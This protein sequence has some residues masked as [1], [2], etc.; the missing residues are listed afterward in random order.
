VVK[1]NILEGLLIILLTVGSGCGIASFVF[2]LD[3]YE[4]CN[5]NVNWGG[6]T[7]SVEDALERIGEGLSKDQTDEIR[8]LINQS[9]GEP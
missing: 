1:Q 3:R 6:Q 2:L 4:P 5:C 7:M 9:C 8:I